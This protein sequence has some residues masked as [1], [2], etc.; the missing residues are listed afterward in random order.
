MSARMTSL[1]GDPTVSAIGFE[2]PWIRISLR[3]VSNRQL[4]E[5][6]HDQRDVKLMFV[7]EN[8]TVVLKLCDACSWH[9]LSATFSSCWYYSIWQ[10]ATNKALSILIFW[11]RKAHLPTT[12][13]DHPV[14]PIIDSLHCACIVLPAPSS[15]WKSTNQ[16]RYSKLSPI[17]VSVNASCI[18]THSI[19][20][21]LG[22]NEY[23]CCSIQNW[24][25]FLKQM[26]FSW[27]KKI[28]ILHSVHG[29]WKVSYWKAANE[30][31]KI[32]F[33]LKLDCNWSDDS[34]PI[35]NTETQIS[36]CLVCFV[37]CAAVLQVADDRTG[38]ENALNRAL[39]CKI[40][41]VP[42]ELDEL[43]NSGRLGGNSAACTRPQSRSNSIP[44]IMRFHAG[45]V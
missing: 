35:A 4:W 44:K 1:A 37:G 32:I 5:D 25:L 45:A 34:I 21:S 15:Q 16:S 13:V 2:Y 11:K 8:S 20:T 19:F 14:Y 24:S 10:R 3:A 38:I 43:Q 12:N 27:C 22:E 31:G 7:V 28:Y 29:W 30:W 6:G 17:I 9:S 36:S 18:W 23:F 40:G 33:I 26:H 41:R 39:V 42:S